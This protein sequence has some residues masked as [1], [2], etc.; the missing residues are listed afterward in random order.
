[1]NGNCAGLDYYPK[2]ERVLKELLQ[3]IAEGRHGQCGE[4]FMTTRFLM[5]Y[6]NISLKTAHKVLG[7]LCSEG[8][9]E[10]RGKRYHLK[11][12]GTG[13]CG[14][15][16][17]GLLL[18]RLDTPYFSNLASCLE[19]RVRQRGAE[20]AIA[21]SSYDAELE[22]THLERFVRDGFCGIAACPWALT[23][24][25]HVYADLSVPCV[26]IGR[27]LPH[28]RTDTV[29]VDNL[30]AAR[31]TAKHLLAA[32]C[33]EFFYAGPENLS[34]DQRLNGFRQELCHNGKKLPE[35]HVAG[36]TDDHDPLPETFR[37]RLL[38][39]IQK[40]HR[41]GIFCYHDL[42]AAHVIGFCHEAKISVPD[43]AAVAGFDNL[44]VASAIWPAMTSVAYPVRGIAETAL[45]MLFARIDGTRCGKG[46]TRL[47][48][49]EL[50][51]RTST[52]IR[53]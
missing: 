17:I 40:G 45:D 33:T 12:P 15:K 2:M 48:A 10:V 51:V 43:Q 5:K 53:S 4:P 36:L 35:D 31:K 30:K 46:E 23:E 16:K 47:L 19:E 9:L 28:E 11:M 41:A 32:G 20:L 49:P 29:L 24:N 6:K 25:E 50:V 21:V 42:Y 22:R 8:I 27:A 26:L 44:P 39:T 38:E 34:D 37:R 13:S 3:E 52:I 7:H 14:P 18:T 1:M